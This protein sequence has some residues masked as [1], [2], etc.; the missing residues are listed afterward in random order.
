M[1]FK[2]RKSEKE[3][4]YVLVLVSSMSKTVQSQEVK[5]Q[6]QKEVSSKCLCRALL[7]YISERTKQKTTNQKRF[8][9]GH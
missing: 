6:S 8:F 5:V 2:K 4:V 3:I 9:R 7:N 1:S